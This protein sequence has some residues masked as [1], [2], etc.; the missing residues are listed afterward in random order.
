M[1]LV[2]LGVKQYSR[3][4][5]AGPDHDHR[6][7]IYHFCNNFTLRTW[8]ECVLDVWTS[9]CEVEKEVVCKPVED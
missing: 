3:A 9:G 5:I 6:A 4:I 2:I 1:S 7:R 8:S